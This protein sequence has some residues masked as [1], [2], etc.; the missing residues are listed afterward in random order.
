MG[1][2]ITLNHNEEKGEV[3]LEF[4]NDL[5]PYF[6]LL[7]SLECIFNACYKQ[8]D[9]TLFFSV[10]ELISVLLDISANNNFTCIITTNIK[11]TLT[12]L[13]YWLNC[14]MRSLVSELEIDIQNISTLSDK[15]GDKLYKI[16]LLKAEEIVQKVFKKELLPLIPILESKFSKSGGGVMNVTG[17]DF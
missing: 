15:E 14:I 13:E 4:L 3:Y 9:N 11:F 12:N 10:D 2:Y 17:C 6:F 5:E 8:K 1:K 7:P 16:V